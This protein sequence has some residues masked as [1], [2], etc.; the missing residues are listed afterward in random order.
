M[1]E[2]LGTESS[3]NR[4]KLFLR[5]IRLLGHI[6]SDRG[7]QQVPKSGPPPEKVEEP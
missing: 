4:T 6:V 7:I 3:P 2:I 1:F 5:K